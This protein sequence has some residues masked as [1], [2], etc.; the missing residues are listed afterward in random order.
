VPPPTYHLPDLIVGAP[1]SDVGG[2]DMGVAYILLMNSNGSVKD[3]GFISNF[4]HSELLAGAQ[5]FA[6]ESCRDELNHAGGPCS[7][8][9]PTAL[10]LV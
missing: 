8:S 10:S 4:T 2:V 3:V 9:L 5:N 1:Q 6:R 7:V